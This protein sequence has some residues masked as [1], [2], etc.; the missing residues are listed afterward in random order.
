[1]QRSDRTV[2]GLYGELYAGSLAPFCRQALA[3]KFSA[4]TYLGKP[5]IQDKGYYNKPLYSP[6]LLAQCLQGLRYAEW[7]RLSIDPIKH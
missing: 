4:K 2:F 1:M 3:K 7:H 6:L 5:E